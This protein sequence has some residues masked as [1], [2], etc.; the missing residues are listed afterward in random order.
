MWLIV[1]DHDHISEKCFCTGLK[2]GSKELSEN[3]FYLLHS[4]VPWALHI[5]SPV[6]LLSRGLGLKHWAPLISQSQ[7]SPLVVAIFGT[8]KCELVGDCTIFHL[9]FCRWNTG[10]RDVLFFKVNQ[11]KLEL[12]HYRLYSVLYV[13]VELRQFNWQSILLQLYMRDKQLCM[14]W[15]P[16]LVNTKLWRHHTYP[17]RRS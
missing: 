5:F 13:L 12:F 3:Q 6:G 8:P 15:Y 11:E 2:F 14:M 10:T 9:F 16:G 4:Q 1:T 17:I 7:A